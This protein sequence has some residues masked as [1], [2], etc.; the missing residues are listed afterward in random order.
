M[1]ISTNVRRQIVFANETAHILN[2]QCWIV[3]VRRRIIVLRHFS[4]DSASN[5]SVDFLQRILPD[6]WRRWDRKDALGG[7]GHP[8]DDGQ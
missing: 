5:F 4:V 8:V 3:A 1:G 7:R 6:I 2:I